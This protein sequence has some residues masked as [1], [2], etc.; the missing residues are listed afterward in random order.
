MRG[1]AA[2]ATLGSR[3]Y[4]ELAFEELVARPRGALERVAHFFGL[5]TG[6]WLERA[7]ALVRGA[8]PRRASGLPGDEAAALAEACR[9]GAS[10]LGRA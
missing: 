2:R 1:L 3:R 4:A 5:A 9:P 10:L 7:A 6:P 8:P